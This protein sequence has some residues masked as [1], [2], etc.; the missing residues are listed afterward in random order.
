MLADD[1]LEA[2]DVGDE[3][4]AQVVA[5]QVGPEVSVL[6]A[7]ELGVEGSELGEGLVEFAGGGNGGVDEVEGEGE[8]GRGE[9]GHG[10]DEGVGDDLVLHAVRVEL[11]A[12]IF[13]QFELASQF[14]N[15]AEELG[16][17]MRVQCL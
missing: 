13:A 4:G 2:G 14:H 16:K 17:K 3:V 6:G 5:V 15:R 1:V 12:V 7:L 10:L 11:V 9:L 8:L